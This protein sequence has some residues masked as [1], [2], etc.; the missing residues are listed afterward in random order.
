[1]NLP[2]LLPLKKEVSTKIVCEDDQTLLI[3][4]MQSR[5]TLFAVSESQRGQ[6][7]ATDQAVGL[8]C[9]DSAKEF[10]IRPFASIPGVCQVSNL[11]ERIR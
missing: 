2:Y 7:K 4:A 5:A 9:P 8:F 3:L 1:V 10:H 11:T 6:R